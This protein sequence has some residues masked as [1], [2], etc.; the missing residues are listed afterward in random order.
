M[1]E[2]K[3]EKYVMPKTYKQVCKKK[4]L[5]MRLLGVILDKEQ[6]REYESAVNHCDRITARITEKAKRCIGLLLLL[7]LLLLSSGC[8]ENTMRETGN[9][10]QAGGRLVT[11]IGTDW[12]R[13]AEGYANGK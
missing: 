12:T 8:I 6:R 10:I 7:C 4:M 5:F 11:G 1:R 3:R 13:G 2:W 9:L